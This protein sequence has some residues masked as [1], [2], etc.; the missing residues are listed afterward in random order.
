MFKEESWKTT[1][2]RDKKIIDFT[3]EI[4]IRKSIVA[5][6]LTSMFSVCALIMVIYLSFSEN[7][8]FGILNILFLL[9]FS[10]FAFF[11][12]KGLFNNSR[13][14]KLNSLGI[15]LSDFELIKWSDIKTTYILKRS[16][17]LS[18]GNSPTME[19][20]YLNIETTYSGMF[21]KKAGLR[22]Y[23][24]TGLELSENEISNLVESFR[25][26]FS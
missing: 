21:S 16:Y 26:K 24:I 6:I 8:D 19:R 5:N 18:R 13:V 7:Y 4:V 17:Y 3:K 22:T 10:L 23:E 25:V 2:S 14:I 11:S 20:F 15:V 9:G 1:I 12:I